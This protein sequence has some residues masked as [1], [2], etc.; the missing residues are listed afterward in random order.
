MH[1]P[2]TYT[3]ECLDIEGGEVLLVLQHTSPLLV[4]VT[5]FRPATKHRH[6]ACH[7]LPAGF[8]AGLHRGHCVG[9]ILE[10]N[11]IILDMVLYVASDRPIHM[12]LLTGQVVQLI[13]LSLEL[14]LDGL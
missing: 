4:P 3:P 8:G 5:P 1:Y 10:H 11:A 6:I 7:S 2:L 9:S 13:Q 14:S 12:D